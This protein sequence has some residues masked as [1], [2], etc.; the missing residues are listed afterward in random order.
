MRNKADAKAKVQMDYIQSHSLSDLI[1]RVNTY[2]RNFPDT[3]IL[4]DDIVG[5]MNEEGTH[6]LLYY[7]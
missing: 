4:K 7:K 6:I 3:P 1:L 5:I 2:N